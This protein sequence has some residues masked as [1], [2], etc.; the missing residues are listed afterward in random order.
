M[1]AQGDSQPASPLPAASNPVTTHVPEGIPTVPAVATFHTV[2]KNDTHRKSTLLKTA[3]SPVKH[4]GRTVSAHILFDEGSQHSFITGDL[5][6]QLA[7]TSKK[8]EPISLSTFGGTS[9]SVKR[10]A[11]STITL[12]THDEEPIPIEVIIVPTIAAPIQN[13]MVNNFANLITDDDLF[14]IDLR[15]GA[16]H[17]WNIVEDRIVRGSGPTAQNPRLVISCLDRCPLPIS[18][19]G[20][21]HPSYM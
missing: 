3:I 15:I 18:P 5:A 11:V 7:L 4:H 19:L 9:P 17:Y 1:C 6:R 21:R 12:L 8:E 2:Q 10:V 13:Q 14:Q 16:D 20:S